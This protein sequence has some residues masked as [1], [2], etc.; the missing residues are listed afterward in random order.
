MFVINLF[1]GIIVDN[2]TAIRKED[3]GSSKMIDEDQAQWVDAMIIVGVDG[4]PCV[5]ERRTRSV[6]SGCVMSV[7]KKV[8]A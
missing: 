2:F 5:T 8:V 4:L 6:S 1:V 7:A 3:D